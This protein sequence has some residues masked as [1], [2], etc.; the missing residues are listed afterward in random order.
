MQAVLPAVATSVPVVD[1]WFWN[2]E[3]RIFLIHYVLW[4]AISLVSGW[5]EV[6]YL[7]ADALK[8]I[9]QILFQY[10]TNWLAYVRYI[11]LVE[12]VFLLPV[13]FSYW[14]YLIAARTG[15]TWAV[16][17]FGVYVAVYLLILLFIGGVAVGLF[18]L[19]YGEK[20]SL[21]SVVAMWVYTMAFIA[22]RAY[23]R[24]RRRQQE[25]ELQRTQ[26]ELQAL[27]AQVNPHFMFNTL[28]N[29]YGTALTGNMDRTA[30]GIEQLSSVMRHITE[31]SQ[32]DFIPIAQELRFVE[33]TVDLHRMRI[34]QSDTIQIRVLIDWDEKP[35]QI[36]P[37]L[38]NPLVENAFKYGISM[39]YP[40]F[41]DIAIQVID[42][43]LTGT[44][45]NQVVPRTNLEKGTG[46]GLKNVR[47]RLALAYPNR[48]SLRIEE[49]NEEFVVY[50]EIK[51]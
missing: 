43:V 7:S 1:R 47:Q 49:T 24:N 27:K 11:M 32:R 17:L 22:I 34:P 12:L 9:D 23:R 15:K 16:V 18:K 3:V 5:L 2:R 6:T 8:K 46:T 30:A 44:I 25:L 19:P 29:L 33:D 14:L 39:Q 28:N 48:H 35:A 10:Q 42:D 31:A 26:A 41:L 50:L 37:L 4:I 51:L 45:R 38:L 13:H 36:V 21:T 20:E 40:C